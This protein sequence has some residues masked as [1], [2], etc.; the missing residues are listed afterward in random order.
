MSRFMALVVLLLLAGCSNK[1]IYDNI[2][3]NNR[4]DCTKLP[5]SQYDSCIEQANKSYEEYEKERRE[6]I[7]K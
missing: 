3:L 4:R 6:A 5:P 2:Q 7:E 1:A